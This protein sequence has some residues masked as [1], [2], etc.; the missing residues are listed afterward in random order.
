MM[1]TSMSKYASKLELEYRRDGKYEHR[2]TI[3]RHK[4]L[5]G[6]IGTVCLCL[7]NQLVMHLHYEP[8]VDFGFFKRAI[9]VDHCHLDY[10]S[11]CSLYGAVH[12][13]SLAKC[14][15]IAVL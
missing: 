3:T 9:Y 2:V 12:C 13:N 10:V 7:D 6:N 15:K 4:D 8:C 11:G 1:D 5:C 14:L